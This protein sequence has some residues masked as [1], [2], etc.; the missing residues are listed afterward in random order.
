MEPESNIP[1]NKK[2]SKIYFKNPGGD[3]ST[4][5]SKDPTYAGDLQYH[6]FQQSRNYEGGNK[7]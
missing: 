5:A 4:L 7:N 6:S 2:N 1:P 3:T